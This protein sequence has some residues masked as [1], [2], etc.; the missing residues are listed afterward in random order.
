MKDVLHMMTFLMTL[1]P[2]AGAKRYR[3]TGFQPKLDSS[4]AS[5]DGPKYRCTSARLA[6][7]DSRHAAMIG[8]S[9]VFA[10]VFAR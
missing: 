6:T 7:T 5:P 8:A 2:Y 1:A 9:N 3:D 4:F 10:T